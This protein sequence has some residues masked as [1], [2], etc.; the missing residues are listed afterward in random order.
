[1]L[2]VPLPVARIEVNGDGRYFVVERGDTL[3]GIA[4]RLLGD[5]ERYRDLFELNVVPRGCGWVITARC[6]RTRI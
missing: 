3:R 2:D 5:E 6:N 4:A 1:M